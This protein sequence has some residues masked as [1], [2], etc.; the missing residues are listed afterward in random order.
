MVKRKSKGSNAERELIHLFWKNK[1][2][3]MRAASTK[4]PCPDIIAGNNLRRYAIEC[5]VTKDIRQYFT[6]NEIKELKEFAN[7]FGAIPLI[8]IKFNN[9]NWFFFGLE[10]LRETEQNYVV[11]LKEA[12]TKGLLFKDI[13][14]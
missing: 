14:Q 5:K 13:I 4:H 9:V 7:L 8:A 1:W 3:A 12:N 2:A 10:D 11:S 6:K